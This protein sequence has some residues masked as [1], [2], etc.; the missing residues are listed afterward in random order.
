MLRSTK[1]LA[2][3]FLAAGTLLGY[4]AASGNLRLNRPADA[5]PAHSPAV[6]NKLVDSSSASAPVAK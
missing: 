6:S 5:S 2:V 4:A 3:I 1:F